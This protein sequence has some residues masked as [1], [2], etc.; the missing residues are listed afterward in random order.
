MYE[1]AALVPTTKEELPVIGIG[2]T[3]MGNTEGEV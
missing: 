3:L 2:H 1:L